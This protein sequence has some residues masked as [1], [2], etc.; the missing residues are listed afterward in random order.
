[1][2]DTNKKIARV[3][4]MKN[5]N[6]EFVRCENCQYARHSIAEDRCECKKIA[7]LF[8][9][10]DFFCA[11]GTKREYVKEHVRERHNEM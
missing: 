4:E 1:M 10:P 5:T 9:E 11:F 8:C 2:A 7:G 6:L 3:L